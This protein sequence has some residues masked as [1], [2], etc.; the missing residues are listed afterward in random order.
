MIPPEYYQGS[1]E[2]DARAFEESAPL[3]DLSDDVIA[4]GA[5]YGIPSHIREFIRRN[6]PDSGM[7]SEEQIAFQEETAREMF[8]Q[9]FNEAISAELN[10]EVV[11]NGEEFKPEQ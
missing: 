8:N 10:P 5:Y 6:I 9:R 7:P 11:N 2:N 4:V 1:D 3:D